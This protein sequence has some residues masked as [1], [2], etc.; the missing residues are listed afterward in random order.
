MA[1]GVNRGGVRLYR[2][3]SSR[4]ERPVVV[5][6][7]E[8]AIG[9]LATATVAQIA[10]SIRGVPSEVQLDEEDG[11]NRPCAVNLHNV[12]TV[13]QAARRTCR[14]IAVAQTR[15]LSRR[16]RGAKVAPGTSSKF[17]DR[18]CSVHRL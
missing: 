16:Y 8:S 10:S 3:E 15:K 11:M 7:R 14:F 9:Y 2:L 5:L 18:R 17:P 4:K 12:M 6:T 13:S 1:R